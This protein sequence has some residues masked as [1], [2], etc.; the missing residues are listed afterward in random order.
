MLINSSGAYP[1]KA[2]VAL[3]ACLNRRSSFAT[4]TASFECSNMLRYFL[5]LAFKALSE[6]DLSSEYRIQRSSFSVL[7]SVFTR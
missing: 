1:V 7:S 5:S 6:E 2:E 4:N 3:L